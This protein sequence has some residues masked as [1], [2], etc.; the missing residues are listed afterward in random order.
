MTETIST[1]PEELAALRRF[2]GAPRDFWPRLTVAL[3]D[4]VDADRGLLMIRGGAEGAAWRK[5]HDWSHN[6]LPAA[7]NGEWGRRWAEWAERTRQEGAQVV[8]LASPGASVVTLRLPLPDAS[9]PCVGLF[10]LSERSDTGAQEALARLQLAAD[11]PV[12]YHSH[13]A[14]LLARA[15][16]QKVAVSLEALE[17]LNG[18][19]RFFGAAVALCN[20]VA[21]RLGCERVSLGW[22]SG[23]SVKLQAISRT[24]KFNRQMAAAQAL[25]AAMEEAVD[26]ETEV[27]FPAA[28]EA[29]YL[30]RDHGTF[31]REQGVKHLVSI[32]VRKGTQVLGC[33]TAERAAAPFREPD[34]LQL[35][36]TLEL[37]TP[38]LADLQ[39]RDRWVGAR[40]LT[41]VRRGSAWWVGPTH[42]GAKLLGLLAVVTILLL[43]FLRVPYRLEGTFSLRSDDL[44]YLSAPFDGYLAEVLVR[45]GDAVTNGQPLLQL[46]TQD[47]RLEES[48]ALADLTRYQREVEKARAE[49]ALADMRIA[50][51]L[52]EQSR[53]RLELVRHRLTQAIL[54]S[55]FAGVVVEGDLRD[56]L[57]APARQGDTLFRVAQLHGLYVQAEIPE[58]DAHELAAVTTG[59]IAFHSQPRLKFPVRVRAWEPAAVTRETGNVFLV[60]GVLEA[61]PEPWFR[62]GMSGVIKLDAGR[63]PV[64][65]I[66]SH[67]TLDFLR[68]FFWW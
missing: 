11:V 29:P 58:R 18:Q 36:L 31:A 32:P 21:T 12:S 54:R 44:A 1:A 3:A 10:L 5:L 50:Q 68:L 34:L 43:V 30:S 15:E 39:E 52:L 59:E 42:T 26:Q 47:L 37:A 57:G 48:S 6:E 66:L 20:A 16:T 46:D 33:L 38:R 60:R 27:V 62:P 2:A 49:Q 23:G 24:E 64:I 13:R 61:E 51:S 19:S 35:R 40:W 9:E 8:P 17:E 4:L 28:D 45:P 55:P 7:A 56:R 22:L 41:A 67:R 65:W 25:E 14:A 63:R 53:A